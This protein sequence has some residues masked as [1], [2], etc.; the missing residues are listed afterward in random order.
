MGQWIV[1]LISKWVL[2]KDQAYKSQKN[3]RISKPSQTNSHLGKI[4]A[5]FTKQFVSIAKFYPVLDKNFR[6]L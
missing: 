6:D 5:P 3:S 1:L 2:N 4:F